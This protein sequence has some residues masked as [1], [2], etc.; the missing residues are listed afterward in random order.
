L[1]LCGLCPNLIHK[2]H[3]NQWLRRGE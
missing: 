2:A 3:S 1:H